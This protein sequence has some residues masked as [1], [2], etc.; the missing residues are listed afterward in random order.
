A[1]FVAFCPCAKADS[2]NVA[3]AAT[4]R[5]NPE[6]RGRQHRPTAMVFMVASRHLIALTLRWRVRLAFFI[7]LRQWIQFLAISMFQ[8]TPTLRRESRPSDDDCTGQGRL[9][10]ASVRHP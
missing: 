2:E 1:G 6:P 4:A 7:T 8:P 3:Q 9:E 5:R 10:S